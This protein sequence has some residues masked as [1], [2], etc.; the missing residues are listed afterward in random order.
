MRLHV[1]KNGMQLERP[2][3]LRHPYGGKNAPLITY[4]DW[5]EALV[6]VAAHEFRHVDQ[7]RFGQR[8]SEI[9][10]ERA[11]VAMLRQWRRGSVTTT[12]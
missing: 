8:V 6:G 4:H 10:C 2:L 12:S 3:T 7:Y 1:T 11:A 5:R 9:A